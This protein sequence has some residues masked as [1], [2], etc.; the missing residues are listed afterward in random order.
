MKEDENKMKIRWKKIMKHEN[1]MK[2]DKR[3]WTKTKE[4]WKEIKEDEKKMEKKM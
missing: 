3:W 4:V 1:N 2:D